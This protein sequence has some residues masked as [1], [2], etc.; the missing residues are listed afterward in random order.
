M[1]DLIYR[2]REVAKK[3]QDPDYSLRVESV[4]ETLEQSKFLT[5]ESIAFALNRVMRDMLSAPLEDWVGRGNQEIRVGDWLEHLSLR[6]AFAH[7]LKVWLTGEQWIGRQETLWLPVLRGFAKEVQAELD[8]YAE[9]EF[10]EHVSALVARVPADEC[11]PISQ[12]AKQYAVPEDHQYIVP[13]RYGVAWATG[14]ESDEAWSALAEDMLLFEGRMPE[15]VRLLWVPQ[16]MSPDRL[17]DIMAQFREVFPP[18]EGTEGAL[19]MPR[20]FL[21]S[22]DTPRAYGPGFLL[23]KGAPEWTTPGHIRWVEYQDPEE[24]EQWLKAHVR[25][26]YHVAVPSESEVK[27]PEQVRAIPWGEA[28][29]RPLGEEPPGENLLAFLR[30]L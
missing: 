14:N 30:R 11:P 1:Q 28:H 10:W 29:R 20:A 17:L 5:E 6:E 23:S 18:A 24:V 27:V 2:I 22:A 9:P 3:W 13:L 16:G 26:I 25:E 19:A 12:Q 7:L 15:N 21:E 4:Q 8:A